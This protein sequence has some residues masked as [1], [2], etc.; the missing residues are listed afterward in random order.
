M[1]ITSYMPAEQFSESS[2]S[3]RLLISFVN[4]FSHTFWFVEPELTGVSG[5]VD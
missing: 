1:L 2:K 5:L 3:I 4:Q